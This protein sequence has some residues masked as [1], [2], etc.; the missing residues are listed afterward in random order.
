MCLPVQLFAL[1]CSHC[2]SSL[3][4]DFPLLARFIS[5]V[6]SAF[7]TPLKKTSTLDDKT[8]LLK[9]LSYWG[10]VLYG[11]DFITLQFLLIRHVQ[12][13]WLSFTHIYRFALSLMPQAP[14]L[15]WL[16]VHFENS[17]RIGIKYSGLFRGECISR[18]KKL[19][20]QCNP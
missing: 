14:G 9:C 7:I 1:S 15:M 18:Q 8:F 2:P 6:T 19:E 4:E 3:L 12:D 16:Q 5:W 13:Y 11:C 17:I 20:F 10:R